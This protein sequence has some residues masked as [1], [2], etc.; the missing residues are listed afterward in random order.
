[1]RCSTIHSPFSIELFAIRYALS[2]IL[3]NSSTVG[4]CL[5]LSD[6]LSG[7]EAIKTFQY[8]HEH[9]VINDI[10]NI[11]YQVQKSGKEVIIAWI[12]G[13]VGITG[14]EEADKLA[15]KAT[16]SETI[17]IQKTFVSKTE[18]KTIIK[19]HCLSL[20]DDEYKSTTKGTQYKIF[21]PSIFQYPASC[22]NRIA[23]SII[24]RLRSGHCQLNNHLYRI[25][26]KKSPNCNYCLVPETVE[27]FLLSCPQYN[28][29]RSHLVQSAR[30]LNVPLTLHSLL[31]EPEILSRVVSFVISS[32]N[33]I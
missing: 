11:L 18:A 7:L 10:L 25:G 15:R 33:S 20:W 22:C 19:R 5:L 3:E 2:W 24:F 4:S 29:Q 27:H 21:Q 28:T 12:P 23:S 32:K 8:R 17:S 9:P 14:N 30:Q 13:H 16:T 26:S 31:T 6:C 1:M